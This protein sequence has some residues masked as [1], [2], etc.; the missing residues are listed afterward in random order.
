MKTRK[1]YTMTM[2]R[3]LIDKG[4]EPIAKVPSARNIRHDVW[5]FESTPEFDATCTE[6]I[7]SH[8]KKPE[9]P[10]NPIADEQLADLYYVADWSV[11]TIAR[12][13]GV[14]VERVLSAVHNDKRVHRALAYARLMKAER[15]AVDDLPQQ[16]REAELDRIWDT[17]RVERFPGTRF[18]YEISLKDTEET[19]ANER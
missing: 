1:I 6:Y 3:W 8:G 13:H 7:N 10:K 11:A 4:F 9:L 16:E 17:F 18:A 19:A 2:A 5:I 12:V 15:E 14:S